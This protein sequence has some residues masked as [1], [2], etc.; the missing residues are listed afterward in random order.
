MVRVADERVLG[1]Q[2]SDD[3][4]WATSF[5][6]IIM[7]FAESLSKVTGGCPTSGAF[8]EMGGRAADSDSFSLS[9]RLDGVPRHRA[10]TTSMYGQSRSASKNYAT[11]IAIQ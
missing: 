8:R 9:S 5:G 2:F 1:V 4:G 10:S 6:T 3:G 7:R 11:C